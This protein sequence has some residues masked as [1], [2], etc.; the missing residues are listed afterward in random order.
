MRHGPGF[1]RLAGSGVEGARLVRGEVT[2]LEVASLEGEWR[3]DSLEGP[4]MVRS[5]S[6]LTL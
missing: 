1:L 3:V 6:H 5:L 2:M 4:G